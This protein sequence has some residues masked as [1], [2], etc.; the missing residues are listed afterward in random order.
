MTSLSGYRFTERGTHY[1]NGENRQK[2]SVKFEIENHH[3]FE[4]D[5]LVNS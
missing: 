4:N 2:K 3:I 1:F 5:P